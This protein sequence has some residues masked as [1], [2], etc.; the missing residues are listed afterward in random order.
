MQRGWW[1]FNHNLL[2]D[3]NICATMTTEEKSKDSERSIIILTHRYEKYVNLTTNAPS[4]NPQFILT[5]TPDTTKKLDL[6]FSE[7][8]ALRCLDQIIQLTNIM[9]A[10]NRIC[11]LKISFRRKKQSRGRIPM[12]LQRKQVRTSLNVTADWGVYWSRISYHQIGTLR[13]LRL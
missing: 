4:L 7:G 11:A 12:L 6:N 8:T 5:V 1:P 13:S 9:E 3:N 2:L 10:R